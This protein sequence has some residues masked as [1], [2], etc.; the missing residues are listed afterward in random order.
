VSLRLRVSGRVISH[1]KDEFGRPAGRLVTSAKDS[2]YYLGTPV[3]RSPSSVSVVENPI[4]AYSQW[5]LDLLRSR[6]QCRGT[7]RV[8]EAEQD[9]QCEKSSRV[10]EE[11]VDFAD[12]GSI[13]RW[14]KFVGELR[15]AGQAG[16]CFEREPPALESPCEDSSV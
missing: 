8:V 15:Y 13:L 11:G 3:G 10:P 6:S 5:E 14:Q 16:S 7:V 2:L 9:R 12:S 1:Q 4:M